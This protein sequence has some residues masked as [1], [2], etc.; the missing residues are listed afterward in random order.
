MKKIIILGSFAA[1]VFSACRRDDTSNNPG[2]SMNATDQNF[3]TMAAMSNNAEVRT[4]QLAV[5]RGA[6]A[7]V[8]SFGQFMVNE[9][10]QAQNDLTTVA[11]NYNMRLTDSIATNDATTYQT[12]SGLS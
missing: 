12:L 11:S 9:H 7:G 8:K 6:N 1:L 10:T 4:G 2:N 3:I 5:S